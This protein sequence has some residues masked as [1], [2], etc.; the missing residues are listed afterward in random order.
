VLLPGYDGSGEGQPSSKRSK[1]AEGGFAVRTYQRAQQS[2]REAQVRM[3]VK[4]GQSMLSFRVKVIIMTMVN[5]NLCHISVILQII[6]NQC[7]QQH[8]LL[9]SPRH[10]WFFTSMCEIR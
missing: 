3:C 8:I 2:D 5:A 10:D 7:D 1:L 4:C 9:L 6:E